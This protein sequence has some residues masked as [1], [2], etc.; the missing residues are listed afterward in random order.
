MMGIV[1]GRTRV[2][3][4]FDEPPPLPETLI[5]SNAKFYLDFLLERWTG[6]EGA[7]TEEA[8]AEYLRCFSDPA[9]IRASCADYRAIKTDLEHD[10]ADRNRKLKCPMLGLWGSDMAL[11]FP[12]WQTG[13]GLDMLR[14]WR[15][16]AEDVRGKPINC[17]HF[18]AEEAPEETAAEILS[19]LSDH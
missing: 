6:R 5:G 17:G 8:Y 10:E 11:R 9:T 1:S 19:F 18:L 13:K 16:R 12:G 3:L 2:F 14:T 7:I 4:S 15:D